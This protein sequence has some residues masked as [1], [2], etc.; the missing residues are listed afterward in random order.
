MNGPCWVPWSLR[1]MSQRSEEMIQTLCKDGF[2]QLIESSNLLLLFSCIRQ[3]LARVLFC[4]DSAVSGYTR[5]SEQSINGV[6]SG[7]G[8]PPQQLKDACKR[9]INPIRHA[10]CM[11]E[12][13]AGIR[14][15]RGDYILRIYSHTR[16]IF[17]FGSFLHVQRNSR[18]EDGALCP[19]PYNHHQYEAAIGHKF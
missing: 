19:F 14:N 18:C 17:C 13:L 3:I 1:K 16:V 8:F 4:C 7:D 11:N 5:Q 2:L 12:S 6:M 10:S 9:S 15:Q